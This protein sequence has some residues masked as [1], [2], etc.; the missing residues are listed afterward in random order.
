MK[1]TEGCEL[2]CSGCEYTGSRSPECGTCVIVCV[3]SHEWRRKLVADWLKSYSLLVVF[4]FF[5]A[6][7]SVDPA[8]ARTSLW[9]Y[10]HEA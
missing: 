9:L 10:A 2:Q 1:Q 7:R 4:W 5:E 8:K 3:H 6:A